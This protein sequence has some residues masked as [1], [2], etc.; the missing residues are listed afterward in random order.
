MTDGINKAPPPWSAINIF[1]T[2]QHTLG[3]RRHSNT[4]VEDAVWF[5]RSQNLLHS[6]S[7]CPD[8]ASRVLS[9][10]LFLE[11]GL[12][13]LRNENRQTVSYLQKMCQH[14]KQVHEN[15]YSNLSRLNH[16]KHEADSNGP[17]VPQRNEIPQDQVTFVATFMEP[18]LSGKIPPLQ[19]SLECVLGSSPSEAD[20]SSDKH[21]I[22]QLLD[23][24][25]SRV[26]EP[27]PD[28]GQ[29]QKDEPVECKPSCTNAPLV[30][31]SRKLVL[32]T[33]QKNTEVPDS[34]GRNQPSSSTQKPMLAEATSLGSTDTFPASR[35]SLIDLLFG[36]DSRDTQMLRAPEV[37]DADL[38]QWRRLNLGSD[39]WNSPNDYLPFRTRS[40]DEL[41]QQAAADEAHV[42]RMTVVVR[43]GGTILAPEWAT[44]QEALAQDPLTTGLTPSRPANEG[45]RE[46]EEA[47]RDKEASQTEQSP[48]GFSVP[49][50]V[51]VVKRQECN[52]TWV[53]DGELVMID[54][55]LV[56]QQ[57]NRAK[58]QK[59]EPNDNQSGN[60][61]DNGAHK[62]ESS[63]KINDTDIKVSSDNFLNKNVS[64]VAPNYHSKSDDSDIS[65]DKKKDGEKESQG[66]YS[67]S[68]YL[69]NEGFNKTSVNSSSSGKRKRKIQNT[70]SKSSQSGSTSNIRVVQTHNVPLLPREEI[71]KLVEGWQLSD[72]LR[73][74]FL[75]GLEPVEP[76]E[77]L[78][79][80]KV[81]LKLGN[82]E[83]NK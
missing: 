16:N 47:E 80:S 55:R 38:Q 56:I 50:V 71:I 1:Q 25:L 6:A 19:K 18:L 24:L 57:V 27:L 76:H 68:K 34:T 63:K 77:S 51:D 7:L 60:I 42:N 62:N 20:G 70:S 61:N 5:H 45:P 13:S 78:D 52:T 11:S 17:S 81:V 69:P 21:N 48:Q 33:A 10:F 58:R 26:L 3:D 44:S 40:R 28:D 43:D 31:S 2:L 14:A 36:S 46:N 79:S 75:V 4:A 65:N 54:G 15:F 59:K 35:L 53:E 30:G 39:G 9:C 8:V 22:L 82:Q 37:N 73:E 32:H 12:T 41:Q 23:Q 66:S 83:N 72:T 29:F 49:N 64:N 67:K 74:A